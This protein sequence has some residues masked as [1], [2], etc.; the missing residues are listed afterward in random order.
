MTVQE[1]SSLGECCLVFALR[2]PTEWTPT[3]GVLKEIGV[4][5]IDHRNAGI[6]S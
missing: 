6:S 5:F 4:A 3:G 1:P 2:S